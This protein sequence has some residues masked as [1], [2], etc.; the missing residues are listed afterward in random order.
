MTTWSELLG[1]N[2]HTLWLISLQC[3][4][5]K[6]P[7]LPAVSLFNLLDPGHMSS[8]PQSCLPSLLPPLSPVTTAHVSVTH[9]TLKCSFSVSSLAGWALV[10]QGWYLQHLYISPVSGTLQVLMN[11]CWMNDS[12]LHPHTSSLPRRLGKHSKVTVTSSMVFVS[13]IF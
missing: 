7:S 2:A 13:I 10:M 1:Y 8:S 11:V 4:R 9:P 3:V 5:G 12:S 6:C